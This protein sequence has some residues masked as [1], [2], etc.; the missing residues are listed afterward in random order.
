MFDK[1]VSHHPVF[2][3]GPGLVEG[4]QQA[5]LIG[6][7]DAAEVLSGLAAPQFDALLTCRRN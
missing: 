5:E 4:R 2:T 7:Q 1:R 6:E 3:P